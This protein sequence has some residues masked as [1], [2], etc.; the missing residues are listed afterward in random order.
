VESEQPTDSKGNIVD[1]CK[2]R[3]ACNKIG[4]GVEC[5]PGGLVPEI[6]QN[7]TFDNPVAIDVVPL[8]GHKGVVA[9]ANLRSGFF[10]AGLHWAKMCSGN[11]A[12]S[13]QVDADCAAQ[14]AGTCID[15]A[16]DIEGYYPYA[17]MTQTGIAPIVFEDD[18]ET[19]Q[20]NAVLPQCS[21][22]AS[23]CPCA[24][25]IC[26]DYWQS[27]SPKATNKEFKFGGQSLLVL[28]GN[29]AGNAIISKSISVNNGSQY[30]FTVWLNTKDLQGTNPAGSLP[31]ILK[32]EVGGITVSQEQG[33]DWTKYIVPFT[34]PAASVNISIYMEAGTGN[35]IKPSKAYVDM[36]SL[37]PVLEIQNPADYLSLPSNYST[38]YDHTPLLSTTAAYSDRSCRIF[39]KPDALSCKYRERNTG[40]EIQGWR[41]F[42]AESDPKNPEYCLQWW[43]IDL[44][45]G[46]DI[47]KF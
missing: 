43:P 26:L 29:I 21:A 5:D 15:R 3:Q 33:N 39:A 30:V 36:I 46:E 28:E 16:D 10:R 38:V 12:L 2:K 31:N 20:S 41:G 34:A 27:G 47:S 7:Q 40:R 44:I 35:T 32:A 23:A 14:G 13:C 17:P 8:T 24:T 11:N 42:C 25:G 1:M 9:D 22:D 4:D 37:A 19:Y 6:K 18:F 45:E